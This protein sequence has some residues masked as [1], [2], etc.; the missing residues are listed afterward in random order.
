[1]LQFTKLTLDDIGRTRLFFAEASG[2]ICDGTLGG[3]FMWRDYFATEY[4]VSG[5]TLFLKVKAPYMKGMEAFY[6]PLGGCREAGVRSIAD[7]CG[8]KGVPAAFFMAEEEDVKLITRLLGRAKIYTENSW[9]DYI[10]N[11]ADLINLPGRKYHGQKNHI[12]HLKKTGCAFEEISPGNLREVKD[13]FCGLDVSKKNE[14]LS[15][16]RG[17]ILEVLANYR[18]YGMIGGL[19]RSEGQVVAFAVGERKKNM[20]YVHIE[21]AD[22]RVRG[23]YQTICNEFARHF[24]GDGVEFVNREED[25]GDEGLRRSKLSYH[26]CTLVK[27]YIT[28]PA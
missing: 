4:A 7:Y 9:S 26:P 18:K 20:L 10:Y 12:N 5:G 14:L 15:E 6:P 17:K 19:L 28:L 2:T 8:D 22:V 11:A 25:E 23:A 13:F 1:M 24:A 16:E 3:V 21:K 27:K